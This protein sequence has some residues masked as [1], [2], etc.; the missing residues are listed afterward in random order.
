[1]SLFRLTGGDAMGDKGKPLPASRLAT[2]CTPDAA[3]SECMQRCCRAARAAATTSTSPD[4]TP[5]SRSPNYDDRPL[6]SDADGW[7]WRDLPVRFRHTYVGGPACSV[8]ATGVRR[9]KNSRC[10]QDAPL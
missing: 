3:A 8:D 4:R 10:V 9:V 7:T 5:D 2:R 6:L 1:M